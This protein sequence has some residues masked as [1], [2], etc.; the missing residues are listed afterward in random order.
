MN[1]IAPTLF[2]L[3]LLPIKQAPL[4]VN[5]GLPLAAKVSVAVPFPVPRDK[6][7]A[8]AVVTFTVTVA[9]VVMVTRSPATGT[10]PPVH[11]PGALQLPPVVVLAMTLPTMANALEVASVS[12]DVLAVNV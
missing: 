5:A 11:V 10:T 9:P 1:V 4:T 7:P 3:T 2:A 8:A 12:P 6:D